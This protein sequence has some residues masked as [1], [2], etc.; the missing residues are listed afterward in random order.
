MPVGAGA[1]VARSPMSASRRILLMGSASANAAELAAIAAMLE[2]EGATVVVVPEG[3]GDY[4]GL[5]DDIAAADVVV[6]WK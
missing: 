4:E 1:A 6:C 2:L 5:L 3:G